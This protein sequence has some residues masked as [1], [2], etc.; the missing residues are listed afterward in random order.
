VDDKSVKLSPA[1][2]EK[3]Y[4]ILARILFATKHAR[5]DTGTAVSFLTM[6]VKEPDN[7]DWQKLSHLMI[8][9]RATKELPLILGS[10]GIGILKWYV[11]SSFTV[12]PNMR[13][14]TSGG[15][16]LGRGYPISAS[17]KQ[18]MNTHSL[19]ESELV[20]VD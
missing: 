11:D 7:D 20:G 13:G 4:S 2:K 5:P 17:T 16:T 10:D 9:I 18:N 12:H 6:R 15:L 3:F 19:T 14:H 8:F 1:K